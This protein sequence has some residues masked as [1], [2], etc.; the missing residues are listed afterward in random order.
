MAF[1][2]R[3]DRPFTAEFISAVRNQLRQA[4]DAL[5]EQP[6]GSHEAIHDARKKFKRVRALYRLIQP[7]AKQFRHRENERIRTMAKTLSA[8]RDAAALIETVD[9]LASEAGSPEELAAPA[10]ASAALIERRDRIA[11]EAID[12]SEEH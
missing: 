10:T 1:R 6:E 8:V 3:P 2:L 7:D 12:R 4:I 5:E 11:S 9:Y